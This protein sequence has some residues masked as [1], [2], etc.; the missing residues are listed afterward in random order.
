MK[1]TEC[2][3]I[4]RD[5]CVDIFCS[6][7]RYASAWFKTVLSPLECTCSHIQFAI[8]SARSRCALNTFT[9]GM[10]LERKTV[11]YLAYY[12]VNAF[13]GEAKDKPVTIIDDIVDGS[14]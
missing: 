3:A 9:V 12:L 14:P 7:A 10:F 4:E 2:I 13:M 5:R 8:P 1:I 6:F 11:A